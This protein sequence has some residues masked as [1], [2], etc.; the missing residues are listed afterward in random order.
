MMQMPLDQLWSRFHSPAMAEKQPLADRAPHHC[1]T[2]ITSKVLQWPYML[3]MLELEHKSM[4][5]RKTHQ[6]STSLF[7][8]AKPRR[9]I[10]ESAQVLCSPV[11]PTLRP[12]SSPWSHC[13]ALHEIKPIPRHVSVPTTST[14]HSWAEMAEQVDHGFRSQGPGLNP[15]STTC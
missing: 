10:N 1:D 12:L 11:P 15:S 2:P 14:A 3:E 8:S 4:V 7:S 9:P 5:V 6:A 13:Q